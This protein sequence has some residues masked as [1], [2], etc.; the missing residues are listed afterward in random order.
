MS[1]EH[2]ELVRRAINVLLP[3]L[4]LA[5]QLVPVRYHH[6]RCL[7]LSIGNELM[8]MIVVVFVVGD[9]VGVGVVVVG[10]GDGVAVDV[11]NVVPV[12]PVVV[13][14]ILL[15]VTVVDNVFVVAVVYVVVE[16]AIER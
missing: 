15:V 11:G 3:F 4:R 10:S 13:L 7:D 16:H 12:V 5:V 6:R 9:D 2:C 1:N 14:A 8:L